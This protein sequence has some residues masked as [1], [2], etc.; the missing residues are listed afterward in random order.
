MKIADALHQ[1]TEDFRS[2]YH[3]MEAGYPIVNPLNDH[4]RDLIAAYAE[5]HGECWL[6]RINIY[7]HDRG[8]PIIWKWDGGLVYNFGASF[9]LPCF[10]QE[11]VD[12]IVAR[13]Q[14][15]YTGTADDY[16]RISEI[17]KRI[18]QLGGSYLKWN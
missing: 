11:L 13:D 17:F 12:L 14:A 5:E 9:V 3:E 4:Q 16:K 15:A 2:G 8:K 10:D 6:G 1:I 7:D 18:D